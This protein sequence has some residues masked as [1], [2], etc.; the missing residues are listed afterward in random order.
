MWHDGLRGMAWH[1]LAY[2]HEDYRIIELSPVG[3]YFP[4]QHLQKVCDCRGSD[5]CSVSGYLLLPTCDSLPNS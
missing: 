2:I 1:E 4:Q 5:V 3:K